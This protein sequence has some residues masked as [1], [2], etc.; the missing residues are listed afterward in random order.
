MYK[1]P[2][3]TFNWF[4]EVQT[5]CSAHMHGIEE[6]YYKG[7]SQYQE[8]VVAKLCNVGKALILDGKIQSSEYDEWIYHESLVHPVMIAHPNPK[9]VAILGGGEGATLR[10]VLKYDVEKV[11]MV[12]LDREVVEV[13]KK[14]LPEWHKGAFDDPRTELVI[15]DGR[16]FLEETEPGSFDVIILDLVDPFEG[17]PAAKLYTKEFYQLVKRALREGGIMVTQ[18]TSTSYTLKMFSV[19]YRTVK[20]VFANAN[21]YHSF[22]QAFD[23][24]WGFVWGSDAIN[25]NELKPEEV[26]SR[27]KA[28]VRGE[29]RYYDG[30]THL[31]MT[32][33]PKHVRK[34]MESETIVST[35]EK[36][37][38][39]EV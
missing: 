24:T 37:F 12:D 20:E 10:E 14:F 16:K 26:D 8:I 31:S 33:L 5:P 32:N 19:I 1:V 28:R 23:S 21:G 27:I 11:V 39:L 9:R 29:L 3:K 25:L 22:I 6:V 2:L 35:D 17:G 7:R 4:I 34:A 15:K 13:A 18:A 36:P 38:L 30:L